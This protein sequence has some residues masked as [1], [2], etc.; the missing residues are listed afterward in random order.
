M[1]PYKYYYI[2]IIINKRNNKAFTNSINTYFFLIKKGAN[3]NI[4]VFVISVKV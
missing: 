3:D 4:L 1:P 2:Y